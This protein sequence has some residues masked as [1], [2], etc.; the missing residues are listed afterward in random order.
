M[1]SPTSDPRRGNPQIHFTSSDA[2]G[3]GP[4][5]GLLEHDSV[6]RGIEALDRMVKTAPVQVVLATYTSPGKWISL[7][8]GEVEDVLQSLRRGEEETMDSVVDT[9]LLPNLHPSVM[10]A[11]LGRR[12]EGEMDSLGI[13]ET[14]TVA[15]AIQGADT[16][17]KA[18]VVDL[19]DLRLANALGGKSYFTIAGATAEVRAALSAAAAG[20]REKNLL[21]RE[22]VIPQLHPQIHQ[23][24]R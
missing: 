13:L 10:P 12:F 6:A 2:A 16:A 4:C 18:S 7:I 24:L 9:L 8:T 21:V 11:I 15:S 20:A 19:V 1:K 23:H 14:F 5:I 3:I 22:V 17:A